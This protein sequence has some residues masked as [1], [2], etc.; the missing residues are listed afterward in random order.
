VRKHV[1]ILGW[2]QI[3]LG[4]IDLL[5]GLTAFG[6]LGS[7]G[8]FSGFASGEFAPFG[9]MAL[10]G[11]AIGTVMLIMAL[12]NLICGIGLLRNWGGWVIVL[13]V[14]IGFVNLAHPP[15]GTAIAIYTFWVAWKL[16]K[17]GDL[18]T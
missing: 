4:I 12:P 3:A 17:A 13:A 16:Y 8:A 10:L 6:V 14:I 1:R 7:I 18:P 5:I 9:I 2:L 15:F 11:G